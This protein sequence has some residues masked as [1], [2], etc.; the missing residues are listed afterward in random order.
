MGIKCRRK[1]SS[2]VKNSQMMMMMRRRI[3]KSKHTRGFTRSDEDYHSVWHIMTSMHQHH[4]HQQATEYSVSRL[5]K[6]KHKKAGQAIYIYI[7]IILYLMRFETPIFNFNER[8]TCLTVI[9]KSPKRKE[10]ENRDDCVQEIDEYILLRLNFT[11]VG[12][13]PWVI[14]ALR[15]IL[16]WLLY[17]ARGSHSSVCLEPN[18]AADEI[19]TTLQAAR[20]FI[21]SK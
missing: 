14:S 6:N 20:L 7:S 4:W 3:T 11:Y 15:S 12:I 10:I 8:S 9:S 17:P 5:W 16:I 19:H 13:R 1:N 2:Y 18:T 21:F